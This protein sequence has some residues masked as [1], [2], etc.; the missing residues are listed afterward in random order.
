MKG[1]YLR[2]FVIIS[3]IL[4]FLMACSSDKSDKDVNENNDAK[5]GTN[6]VVNESDSDEQIELRFA[7]WGGQ[8]RHNR[9][10]DVIELYEEKNPHVKIVPEYSG[11][12][13]YF[14][15]LT[16]QFAGGNAPDIIQYGGN[17]N[18]FVYRDVVLP[19]D[20]YV[21][22]I[23][24]VSL[25][26]QNMIDAATFDGSFY[27]L[28]LGTN[29]WGVLINKTIFDEVGISLPSQD[30]TWDD[31][32]AIAAEISDFYGDIAGTEYFGEDGFGL[33]ITQH[34][35]ILHEDGDLKIDKDDVFDWFE[36]W[37]E[38]R[39]TGAVVS[40]EVQAIASRTPE[41]SMI[42][43]REVAMQLVASNQLIAYTGAT[44]DELVLHNHPYNDEGSHGTSLR[45]SQFLAGYANTEHPEEVAKFL[46]FFVNDPEAAKILG[47]E[48][49]APVNS[50]IREVLSEIADEIDTIVYEFIDFVSETSDAPFVPNLPGYNETQALFERISE[51]I[52]FGQIS[53]EEGTDIYWEE[54][55]ESLE[56]HK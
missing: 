48:R 41:Q 13:G 43:Q 12:D 25:H 20:D 31:F 56:K 50:E 24:D 32:I 26:D 4:L 49:G 15:K 10:L 55:L 18:D 22:D 54:L 17:L 8:E 38:I 5:S 34:G 47:S 9:T 29:A 37:E 3:L 42:V 46:D 2:F 21:G 44:D 51:E 35:K 6:E 16:T 7:W 23:I 28:T 33:F 53:V 14:D 1:F 11:I 45:A 27:G 52:A 36:F 39:K 40:P 30:W 19:L